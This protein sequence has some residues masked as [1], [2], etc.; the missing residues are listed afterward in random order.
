MKQKTA[1]KIIWFIFIFATGILLGTFQNVFEKKINSCLD[2]S[3]FDN[4]KIKRCEDAGGKY[5]IYWGYSQ[6][7]YIEYCRVLEKEIE[8]Y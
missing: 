6:K 5:G 7:K 4:R 2:E 8:N 1:L 3:V